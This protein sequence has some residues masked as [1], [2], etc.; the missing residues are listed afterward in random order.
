MKLYEET[1]R[2]DVNLPVE[3]NE[4]IE[5]ETLRTGIQKAV[6]LRCIILKWVDKKTKPPVVEKTVPIFQVLKEQHNDRG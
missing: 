1:V 6:F 3:A 4:F 2:C 5:I